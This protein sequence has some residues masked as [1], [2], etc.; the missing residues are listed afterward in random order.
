MKKF[1]Q[2]LLCLIVLGIPL[3]AKAGDDR[4]LVSEV[5]ATSNYAE[6]IAY[7]RA[8]TIPTVTIA[9]GSIATIP[10]SMIRWQKKNAD[11]GWTF[12]KDSEHS[13]FEE[14]NYR[15]TFQVRIDDANYVLT[16]PY[17]VTVN[18]VKWTTG[19]VYDYTTYCFS[20]AYSPEIT[21]KEGALQFNN[22]S[23]YDIPESAVGQ[24]IK[25]VSVASGVSGGT[26][27][28]TFSKVSGP[29]WITVSAAGT[30]S[31]TPSVMGNNSKLM[32][33]VTDA[34]SASAE[35]TITVGRT[36]WIPVTEVVATSDYTDIIGYGKAVKIP[37]FT[38]PDDSHA[39]I[40]TIDWQKKLG[41]DDWY[42][43]N[44]SYSPHPTFEEGTYRVRVRVYADLDN[45]YAVGNS[46]TFTVNGTAWETF[47][48]EEPTANNFGTAFSPEITV[49]NDTR[50]L[51]S[52]VAATSNYTE[53]IGFG[54]PVTTP[55]F[56]MADGSIAS[57]AA[58]YWAKKQG[59]NM[60]DWKYYDDPSE[61]ATFEEGTYVLMA[62]VLVN[63][64]GYVLADPWTFTVNGTEWTTNT[65]QDETTYSWGAAMS[66]DIKVVDPAGIDN[67]ST[68]E[69]GASAPVY[70]LQGIKMQGSLETLPAGLYILGGKK[71]IKK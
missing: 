60:E 22:S 17:S 67:I 28:Y 55:T 69:P 18:G 50:T 30:V 1:T 71:V 29:D 21:V 8:V 43:Y 37:T 23:D 24:P 49:A 31:G 20:N 12:Y 32:V 34:D 16:K 65:A 13:T 19:D 46:L 52:D 41:D 44:T 4:T 59:E 68:D 56:T 51:I 7:G 11:G 5:I 47:S 10:A 27:P 61:E 2:I 57:V 66:M 42:T 70:N 40:S 39:I 54:K 63:D 26:E 35:I 15:L 36:A 9:E 48:P 3:A 14:G 64:S 38:T 53:I 62:Q 45:H 58:C 25:S 33:R 6:L